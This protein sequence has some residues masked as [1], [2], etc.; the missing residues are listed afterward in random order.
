MKVFLGGSLACPSYNEKEFLNVIFKEKGYELV[1]KYQDADLII[2]TDLCISTSETF[3][4]TSQYLEKLVQNV[5]NGA[6]III[7]GCL[8]D[9]FKEKLNHPIFERKD[10]TI[11]KRSDL[12]EYITNITAQNDFNLESTTSIFRQVIPHYTNNLGFDI[13]DLGFDINLFSR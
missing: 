10:V 3:E 11:V 8:A 6:Q 1:E 7:S 5:K 9:G 13:N 4:Y 12:L 2:L